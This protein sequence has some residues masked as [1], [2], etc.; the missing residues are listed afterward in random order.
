MPMKPIKFTGARVLMG[1]VGVALVYLVFVATPVIAQSLI[2][3]PDILVQPEPVTLSLQVKITSTASTRTVSQSSITSDY[4]NSYT[5]RRDHSEKDTLTYDLASSMDAGLTLGKA[6][7]VTG[8]IKGSSGTTSHKEISWS[9]VNTYDEKITYANS[10]SDTYTSTNSQ[11]VKLDG[12]DGL[13]QSAFTIKNLWNQ[14][15]RISNIWAS[16]ALINQADPS[17]QR[18]IASALLEPGRN[19][20]PWMSNEAAD[21][22]NTLSFELQPGQWRTPQMQI[23]QINSAQMQ[24]WMTKGE[25]PQINVQF[26][27]SVS[28]HPVSPAQAV[29]DALAKGISLLVVDQSGKAKQFF[30]AAAT[31]HNGISAVSA[32]KTAG[33]KDVI[34]KTVAGSSY[35]ASL[36]QKS[37][38]CLPTELGD[39]DAVR[40]HPDEGAWVFATADSNF[41]GSASD[42]APIGTHLILMFMTRR[43][44][45]LAIRSPEDVSRV[46]V[47]TFQKRLRFI[48]ADADGVEWPLLDPSTQPAAESKRIPIGKL[49]LGDIVTLTL[50]GQRTCVQVRSYVP[51]FAPAGVPQPLAPRLFAWANAKETVPDCDTWE[52]I[53]SPRSVGELGIGLDLGLGE[54][55]LDR[56]IPPG[57]QWFDTLPDGTVQVRFVTTDRVLRAGPAL[58]WVVVHEDRSNLL[59]VGRE[60]SL[61]PKPNGGAATPLSAQLPDPWAVMQSWQQQYPYNSMGTAVLEQRRFVVGGEILRSPTDPEMVFAIHALS[62]DESA[63]LNAIASFQQ[64]VH[65]QNLDQASVSIYGASDSGAKRDWISSIRSFLRSN[66]TIQHADLKGVHV[67]PSAAN[68]NT[69][70][71][72]YR[73]TADHIM[74]HTGYFVEGITAERDNTGSWKVTDLDFN[75]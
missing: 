73:V 60:S 30:V 67:V 7:S 58:L 18:T 5:A 71:A 31:G 65:A 17:T 75:P 32:L 57:Q 12:N 8:T 53:P 46:M 23:D 34:V 6:L 28:G 22:T 35:I 21:N 20:Y 54:I 40:N 38:D 9:D 44:R 19:T 52:D 74:D 25:I 26:D 3:V 45:M 36:N 49:F 62:A 72:Y 50:R 10:A 15:V 4:S 61:P 1:Q 47:P 63:A 37:S 56:L 41:T 59:K 43:D 51:S 68:P 39:R 69:V 13:I 66:G 42:E 11:D 64:L 29:Q 14:P 55:A 16:I 24:N 48:A 33:Y 70:V 27:V 2:N